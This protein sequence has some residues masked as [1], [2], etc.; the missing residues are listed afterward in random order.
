MEII[1]LASITLLVDVE[2]L[3]AA[4][5]LEVVEEFDEEFDIDEDGTIWFYDEESDALYYFDE[6]L[7]DWA[8]VDE[9]GIV[10]YLDEEGDIYVYD[11]FIEHDWVL[12]EEDDSSAW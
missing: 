2:E 5:D 6:D 4:L 11:D 9:D 12:Y 1:M 8:E 7:D 3:L 10:W